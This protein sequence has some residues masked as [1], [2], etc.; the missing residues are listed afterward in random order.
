MVLISCCRCCFFLFLLKF[1]KLRDSRAAA[2][3]KG[4]ARNEAD[5][6]CFRRSWRSFLE[7]SISS[8]RE[9]TFLTRECSNAVVQSVLQQFVNENLC[10]PN[11][12][13]LSAFLRCPTVDRAV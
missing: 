1:C 5:L 2:E 3:E 7:V 11:P 10:G 8:G 9:N 12:G 6:E 13:P 4:A